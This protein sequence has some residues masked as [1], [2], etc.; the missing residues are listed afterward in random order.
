MSNYCTCHIDKDNCFWCDY[1]VV[2]EVLETYKKANERYREALVRLRN[3]IN[4]Q[5][6]WYE[7]NVF[8]IKTVDDALIDWEALE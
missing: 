6:T 2:K 8:V 7:K 4:K 5:E 1:Q 3:D